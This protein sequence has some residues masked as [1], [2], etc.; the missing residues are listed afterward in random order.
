MS[1]KIYAWLLHAYPSQFRQAYGDD[2]LKL[3]R[4]RARDET[5]FLRRSRLWWD[6]VT[7]VLAGLPQA[8][9]NSYPD[10]ETTTLSPHLEGIP[11]FKALDK[12]PLR[13][14]SILVAGNISL[15]AVV[16]FGY[17]L[18]KPVAYLP[19]ADSNGRMS[20]IEAVLQRLNRAMDPD[21]ALRM[22]HEPAKSVPG[23][24]RKGLTAPSENAIASPAKPNASALQT[25]SNDSAGKLDRI[26]SDQ[27]QNLIQR[28]ADLAKARSAVEVQPRRKSNMQRVPGERASATANGVTA[29]AL[30][31][32]QVWHAAEGRKQNLISIDLN[33]AGTL[34]KTAAGGANLDA[35]ERQRVLDRVIANV[36]QYYFDHD[37]AQKTAGALLAHQKAGDY[38]AVTDNTAFADLLTRQMRDASHDMHLMMD[39][40]Q[41]KIP[42]SPPAET[43]ED[44]ARYR[45]FLVENNCF[46]KKVEILPHNIG[47]M[48]LDW[49]SDPS[50]CGEKA[51]TAMASLNNADAIIFD[52][53]DNHGGEQ[54]STV[55]LAAY[56]F[57][58]PEYW[59]SPRIAPTL[60]SWTRSPVPGN[61]LAD[62]PVYVLV[63]GSTWSGAEQF[64]YD[65]KMLKRATLVGET[66]RGGA[67]AGVFHRIDDHFGMGIPEV[68][69][70]NPFGNADWEGVGVDPDVRVNAADALETALKLAVG[71]LQ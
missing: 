28:A 60:E 25:K 55:M 24:T 38:D 8:Y 41:E 68:K 11:S 13:R 26:V 4:D 30:S 53:R 22:H 67:H 5:G 14:G 61:K 27:V 52:L 47:Y 18:S 34:A 49:F 2:A 57:D 36:R 15:A 35:A 64:C 62:K 45:K 21:S 16:A 59:Y 42:Q 58:H 7:D 71:K 51:V 12:E 33:G 56:L 40:S 9:R 39:Y 17:L 70:I 23:N 3:F 46:F 63:S 50:I 69:T 1:E 65:L 31:G 10:S 66:T 32:A 37:V 43:S 48:K 20:P 54:G 44:P 19:I 6:L 29:P